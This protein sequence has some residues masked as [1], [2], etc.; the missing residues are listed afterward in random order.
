MI[1]SIDPVY[2]FNHAAGG[3]FRICFGVNSNNFNLSF[4]PF[5]EDRVK[6]D[7]KLFDYIKK[8]TSKHTTISHT[9][10]DLYDIGVPVDDWVREY[11]KMIQNHASGN[12]LKKLI[13][14]YNYIN[15]SNSGSKDF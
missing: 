1:M 7:K 8:N 6:Q 13:L 9:I 12:L 14:F 3:Y 15:N 5:I 10:Y 4:A 2:D 11:V